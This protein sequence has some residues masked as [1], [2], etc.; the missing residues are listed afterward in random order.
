[1]NLCNSHNKC[2]LMIKLKLSMSTFIFERDNYGIEA[3]AHNVLAFIGPSS[4]AIVQKKLAGRKVN[5]GLWPHVIR[6]NI[7]SGNGFLPDGTKPLPEPMLTDQTLIILETFLI[8]IRVKCD[9]EYNCLNIN[10]S[11]LFDEQQIIR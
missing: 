4:V 1:M 11:H 10:C 9:C 8:G 3:N 5:T 6:V 7:G 2:Y